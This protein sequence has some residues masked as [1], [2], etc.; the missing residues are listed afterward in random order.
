MQLNETLRGDWLRSWGYIV[1]WPN[2]LDA[3][4]PYIGSIYSTGH[5]FDH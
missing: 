1:G 4:D 3:G 2:R 5:S